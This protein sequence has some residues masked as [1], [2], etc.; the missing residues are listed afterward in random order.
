MPEPEPGQV[1]EELQELRSR[2]TFMTPRR[3]SASLE[4]NGIAHQDV[5]R[6]LSS[7]EPEYMSSN[8]HTPLH[9]DG[10]MSPDCTPALVSPTQDETFNEQVVTQMQLLMTEK[11]T[12]QQSCGQ[13]E[14]EVRQLREHV[15][16]LESGLGPQNTDLKR[17]QDDIDILNEQL[18]ES[19]R[20]EKAAKDRAINESRRA[21]SSEAGLTS[22]R[23]RLQEA[24]KV[25][26]T[27]VQMELSLAGTK[28]ELAESVYQQQKAIL[29]TKQAKKR[30]S[31]LQQ[32][33]NETGQSFRELT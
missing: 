2:E 5:L 31:A 24:E 6:K 15:C 26:A 9:V 33:L 1:R 17:L 27:V 22:L 28:V 12:L 18:H 4:N 7:N 13:L 29:E 8:L 19:E 25:A 30:M 23:E 10:V 16:L 20:R 21:A 14:R 11:T 3:P 32:Q